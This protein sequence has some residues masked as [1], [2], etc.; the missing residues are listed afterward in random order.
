MGI[1]EIGEP[2]RNRIEI[3]IDEMLIGSEHRPKVEVKIAELGSNAGAVG[4]ALSTDND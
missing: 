4:A 1:C 3:W 2:L